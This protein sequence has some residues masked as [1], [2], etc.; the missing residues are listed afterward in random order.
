VE[1]PSRRF[2]LY[3]IVEMAVPWQN[4]ILKPGPSPQT[5]R[6]SEKSIQWSAPDIQA[7]RV[8]SLPG[9]RRLCWPIMN[10]WGREADTPRW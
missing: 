3:D 10:G 9:S 5:N 7:D 4:I 2:L 8:Q 1:K 6:E